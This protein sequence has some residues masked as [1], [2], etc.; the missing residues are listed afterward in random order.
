MCNSIN[1]ATAAAIVLRR[2]SVSP[3]E[4]LLQIIPDNWHVHF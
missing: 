1:V 3:H 4:S 2:L